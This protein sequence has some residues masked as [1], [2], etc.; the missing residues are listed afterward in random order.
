MGFRVY[1]RVE[2]SGFAV[3]LKIDVQGVIG[4]EDVMIL[5]LPDS[6]VA[7]LDLLFAFQFA[8]R[9]GIDLRL[10]RTPPVRQRIEQREAGTG[11]LPKTARFRDLVIEVFEIDRGAPPNLCVLQRPL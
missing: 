10:D 11:F 6:K 1:C 9:A 2:A 3:E 7:I 4:V 5:E 8:G